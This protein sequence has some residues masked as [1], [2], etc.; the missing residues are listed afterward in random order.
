VLEARLDDRRALRAQYLQQGPVNRH[1]DKRDDLR[2]EAIDLLLENMPAL[3][4]L[5]RPE[6]VDPR[7]GA[8]HQVRHAEAPLGQPH[9]VGVRDPLR[10]KSRIE[11]Q[12]PEPVGGAGKMMPGLCRLDTRVDSDEQHAYAWR[13][14]ILQP[15]VLPRQFLAHGS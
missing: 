8:R 7:T 11:Q 3:E 15:K 10:D 12:L 4:I 9:I 5:S 2:P 14:T 1:P 13:D 6:N